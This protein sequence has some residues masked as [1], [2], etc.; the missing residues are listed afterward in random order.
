MEGEES[1]KYSS[2]QNEEEEKGAGYFKRRL[3]KQGE[4][5]A[6][7][8][9]ISNLDTKYSNAAS[10]SQVNAPINS[11]QEFTKIF[12]PKNVGAQTKLQNSLVPRKNS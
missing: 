5:V 8:G 2:N 3:T 1:K 10:S 7:S 4:H 12:N 6:S 11:Y 9:Q